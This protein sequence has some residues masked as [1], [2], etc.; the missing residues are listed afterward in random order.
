MQRSKSRLYSATEL[1][2]E[3]HTTPRALRFYETK[4][5]LSPRRAGSRRI[6][7]Y[8]D[9]AR[10]ALILRG[11]RLGFSLADIRE[12]LELYEIDTT[13]ICQLERLSDKVAARIGR[14]EHQRVALE[15]TLG[16]LREIQIQ[17]NAVLDTRDKESGQPRS[18]PNADARSHH[19]T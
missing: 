3:F 14:L 19:Q 15:R 16:E 11:K 10:L 17:V 6:Y 13:Q 18:D 12:Y 8:R 1:A 7:D 2:S 4:N 9:R 5:L